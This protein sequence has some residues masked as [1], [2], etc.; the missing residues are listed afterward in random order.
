MS[1]LQLLTLASETSSIL[2][3]PNMDGERLHR[4]LE[5]S[6]ICSGVSLFL[7]DVTLAEAGDLV[8]RTNLRFTDAAPHTK[9]ATHMTP[10]ACKMSLQPTHFAKLPDSPRKRL[11]ERGPPGKPWCERLAASTMRS[12][13]PH[14]RPLTVAM[15]QRSNGTIADYCYNNCFANLRSSQR[16]DSQEQNSHNH[17]LHAA[18]LTPISHAY[19]KTSR[20]NMQKAHVVKPPELV[21]GGA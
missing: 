7:I 21:E 20:V 2:E 5:A 15:T 19:L 13:Q 3:H 1:C 18:R 10:K 16:C 9:A 8:P 4:P 11:G 14:P 12:P 17:K 6:E